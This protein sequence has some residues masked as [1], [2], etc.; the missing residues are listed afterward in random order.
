MNHNWIRAGFLAGFAF[1]IIYLDRLGQL[2]LYVSPGIKLYVKL[3]AVVLNV[4]AIH[5]AMLAMKRKPDADCEECGHIHS[6]HDHDHD[7]NHD[8]DHDH[9]MSPLKSLLVYGLFL[10]PLLLGFLLPAAA[11]E[12]EVN[13][14]GIPH[15]H[16]GGH[17]VK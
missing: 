10:L 7:H 3:S 11:Q 5:Q 9:S 16:S 4:A 15:L 13:S 12:H 1:L 8:H 14:G 17:E 6:H 2:P